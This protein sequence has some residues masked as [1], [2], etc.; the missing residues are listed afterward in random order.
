[1][2]INNK[3]EGSNVQ[4]HY[5]QWGWTGNSNIAED[6]YYPIYFTELPY[7]VYLT[8]FYG[9]NNN[10]GFASVYAGDNNITKPQ[11]DYFMVRKSGAFGVY[12]LAIGL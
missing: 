2:R 5:H 4:T 10:I 7:S 11:K 9:L 1:M 12:W 6:V 3:K 8:G